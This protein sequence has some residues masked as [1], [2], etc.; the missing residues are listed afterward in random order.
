MFDELLSRGSAEIIRPVYALIGGYENGVSDQAA[1]DVHQALAWVA[2]DENR[3]VLALD[4]ALSL[5]VLCGVRE[6]GF[7]PEGFN[8]LYKLVLGDLA[9]WDA[10]LLLSS[11]QVL[12]GLRN[13]VRYSDTE[14]LHQQALPAIEAVRGCRYLALMLERAVL[15]LLLRGGDIVGQRTLITTLSRSITQATAE[16]MERAL[17]LSRELEG[18]G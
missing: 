9:E 1:N 3:E 13:G 6:E 5:L 14:Y 18:A 10:G 11:A 15:D 12:L 8:R 4:T 2:T 7:D 17:A 16:D